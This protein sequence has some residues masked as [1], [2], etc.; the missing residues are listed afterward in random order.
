MLVHF[1]VLEGK[2]VTRAES[3][4]AADAVGAGLDW[5]DYRFAPESGVYENAS[6]ARRSV[7]RQ[8]S[9]RRIFTFWNAPIATR[10]RSLPNRPA[11]WSRRGPHPS[12]V[13]ATVSHAS[14]MR[15][16]EQRLAISDQPNRLLIANR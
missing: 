3:G 7:E 4:T 1:G 15:L 8:P 6:A 11:S 16:T 14:P 9:G 13:K 12:S 5:E 2:T 10:S